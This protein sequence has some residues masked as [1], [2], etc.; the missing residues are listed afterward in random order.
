VVL[1]SF[2]EQQPTCGL[3]A[4]ALGKALMLGRRP[5][6][7]QK[8]YQNARLVEPGSVDQIAQGLRDMREKSARYVAP[9][10]FVEECRTDMVGAKLKRI[11]ESLI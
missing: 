4:A 8:F 11:F 1:P 2:N 3:E 5:Y 6:A 7:L 9:R 10:I